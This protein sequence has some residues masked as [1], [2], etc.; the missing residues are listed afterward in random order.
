MLHIRYSRMSHGEKGNNS[1]YKR[2][3]RNR[4]TPLSHWTGI[5]FFAKCL[6]FSPFLLNAPPL[7]KSEEETP[8]RRKQRSRQATKTKSMTCPTQKKRLATMG[9]QTESAGDLLLFTVISWGQTGVA[10]WRIAEKRATS[11]PPDKGN[12]L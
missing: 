11:R 9:L 4:W 7:H 10:N 6:T 3:P 8:R 5:F 1:K 12:E 2:Q